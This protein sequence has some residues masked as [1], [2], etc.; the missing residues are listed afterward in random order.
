MDG[1]SEAGQKVYDTGLRILMHVVSIN[2]GTCVYSSDGALDRAKPVNCDG[3]AAR[4]S[5]GTYG[6]VL[7]PNWSFLSS[8]RQP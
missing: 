7:H 8:H 6:L 4:L 2:S 5:S 1:N 3:L